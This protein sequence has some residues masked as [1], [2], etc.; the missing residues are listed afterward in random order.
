V[1]VAGHATDAGGEDAVHIGRGRDCSTRAGR[2]DRQAFGLVVA[3]G[4]VAAVAC[5][6]MA[7]AADLDDDE[8]DAASTLPNIYLDLRTTYS[9]VPA[10]TL[11][12]GFSNPSLSSAIAAFQSLAATA[13]TAPLARLPSSSQGVALDVP[14]SMDF[15]D[16][17]TVFGGFSASASQGP[18]SDWSTFAIT[19]WSVGL[20]AD[21]YQQ[22]GGSLPTVTLLTTLTRSVP[23]SPL[24]TTAFNTIIELDYALD[25]DETRGLLAG[26]QDTR[27]AVDS[28]LAA[29][30][31]NLVGY[32]GAY[33]Q[34]PDNWKVSG[35]VGVQSFGGAR[36][37][38]FTQAQPFTQPIVRFDLDRNDDS[39]NRL[40]GVTAQ[41]AWTPKPAYQLTLRTPLYA[42]RN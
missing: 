2:S 1:A 41:I 16:R 34:R 6:D 23:D 9:R 5:Q 37:L 22:N 31:P 33:Y 35:R 28:P 3:L 40:F 38:A 4:L 21:I 17:I 8:A 15:N 39:D 36:L 24:A 25:A 29:I 14:L 30:S 27:V 13:G 7:Q 19:S 12:F 11:S 42:V 10:G 32:V 26:V 20:Q 18:L